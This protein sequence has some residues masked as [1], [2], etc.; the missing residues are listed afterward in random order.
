MPAL[1]VYLLS[2]V[3]IGSVSSTACNT[4]IIIPAQ[5]G[6]GF[7]ANYVGCVYTSPV[8]LISTSLGPDKITFTDVTFKQGGLYLSTSTTY[9]TIYFNSS[10]GFVTT[11]AVTNVSYI[12]Y[13]SL[14]MLNG[15]THSTLVVQMVGMTIVIPPSFSLYSSTIGT[16]ITQDCKLILSDSSAVTAASSSALTSLTSNGTRSSVFALTGSALSLLS[17]VVLDSYIDFNVSMIP[18]GG[19][20]FLYFSGGTTLQGVL[21]SLNNVTTNIVGSSGNGTA[22]LLSEGSTSL[23][24]FS[25]VVVNTIIDVTATNYIHGTITHTVPQTIFGFGGTIELW[26]DVENIDL[27]LSAVT[28][29]LPSASHFILGGGPT[30]AKNISLTMTQGSSFPLTR[31]SAT[32]AFSTEISVFVLFRFTNLALI[33]SN[34]S[35]IVAVNAS[36]IYVTGLAGYLTETCCFNVSRGSSAY[37]NGTTAIVLDDGSFVSALLPAAVTISTFIVAVNDSSTLAVST[38]S[39]FVLPAQLL[40]ARSPIFGLY[41]NISN[42]SLAMVQGTATSQQNSAWITLSSSP[43]VLNSFFIVTGGALAGVSVDIIPS[44]SGSSSVVGSYF[45]SALTLAPIWTLCNIT[46]NTGGVLT[47]QALNTSSIALRKPLQNITVAAV[48]SLGSSWLRS[49]ISVNGSAEL[50]AWNW[51]VGS[52]AVVHLDNSIVY[53][54]FQTV[55]SYQVIPYSYLN[56]TNVTLDD[57]TWTLLNQTITVYYSPNSTMIAEANYGAA[58]VVA[59]LNGSILNWT[60][61]SY[62]DALI[63]ARSPILAFSLYFSCGSIIGDLNLSAVFSAFTCNTESFNTSILVVRSLMLAEARGWSNMTMA[64]KPA[65]LPPAI[66]MSWSSTRAFNLFVGAWVMYLSPLWTVTAN[67]TIMAKAYCVGNLTSNATCNATNWYFPLFANGTLNANPLWW[68]PSVFSQRLVANALVLTGN[69]AFNATLFAAVPRSYGLGSNIYIETSSFRNWALNVT[70]GS[71]ST[72]VVVNGTTACGFQQLD[73]EVAVAEVP[74]S[75]SNATGGVNGTNFVFALGAN[76]SL[77]EFRF[78]QTQI[79]SFVVESDESVADAVNRTN[80]TD[81]VF[82][83]NTLNILLTGRSLLY[84][85]VISFTGVRFLSVVEFGAGGAGNILYREN[86][87]SQSAVSGNQLQWGNLTL[88]AS[89]LSTSL[90]SSVNFGFIGAGLYSSTLALTSM[91]MNCSAPS[92]INVALDTQNVYLSAAFI[93]SCT[94]IADGGFYGSVN[95]RIG[96]LGPPALARGVSL[97]AIFTGLKMTASFANVLIENTTYQNVL[98]SFSDTIQATVNGVY[99]PAAPQSSTSAATSNAGMCVLSNV[100]LRNVLLNN[101]Q[102]QVS[103]RSA[104][105]MTNTFSPSSPSGGLLAGDD[106]MCSSYNVGLVNVTL[107]G[108]TAKV[109]CSLGA[110]SVAH[111]GS[112]TVKTVE[113]AVV[114]SNFF[115]S[116]L[117][118]ETGVSV[119]LS[120]TGTFATSTTSFAFVAGSTLPYLAANFFLGDQTS[121]ALRASFVVLGIASGSCACDSC[122]TY[123]MKVANTTVTGGVLSFSGSGGSTLKVQSFATAS[124]GL[125]FESVSFSSSAAMKVSTLSS[126]TVL[127]FSSLYA[128]GSRAVQFVG[129]TIADS[130]VSFSNVV[131]SSPGESIAFLNTT[132]VTNVTLFVSQSTLNS[133]FSNFVLR[134]YASILRNI[135]IVVDHCVLNVFGDAGVVTADASSTVRRKRG[136]I[137]LDL[138]DDLNVTSTTANSTSS[139]STSNSTISNS[140]NSTV[141]PA[142]MQQVQAVQLLIDGSRMSFTAV[143][144]FTPAIFLASNILVYCSNATNLIIDLL[145]TYSGDAT[146]SLFAQVNSSSIVGNI[147]VKAA[148]GDL[149]GVDVVGNTTGI[150]M[151]SI[152]KVS[153]DW[154]VSNVALMA[155]NGSLVVPTIALTPGN[156]KIT[157][158]NAVLCSAF[159]FQSSN[160]ISNGTIDLTSST[161]LASATQTSAA[162]GLNVTSVIGNITY[163]SV[164]W[165]GPADIE[166]N[167]AKHLSN[168]VAAA[169]L[170]QILGTNVLLS[171]SSDWTTNSGV[172][173]VSCDTSP[174]VVTGIEV[175]ASTVV[176]TLI[177]SELTSW[178]ILST[179]PASRGGLASMM[180]VQASGLSSWTYLN[181]VVRANTQIISSFGAARWFIA[182]ATQPQDRSRWSNIVLTAARLGTLLLKSSA[183]QMWNITNEAKN[184]FSPTDGA[185]IATFHGSQMITNVLLDLN[186]GRVESV[187]DA[188]QSAIVAFSNISGTVVGVNVSIP[189]GS[190]VVCTTSA[191]YILPV[192]TLGIELPPSAFLL[193]ATVNE[194]YNVTMTMQSCQAVNRGSAAITM[195]QFHQLGRVELVK[196]LLSAVTFAGMIFSVLTVNIAAASFLANSSTSTAQNISLTTTDV[197]FPQLL[198]SL[199]N[200]TRSTVEGFT[201]LAVGSTFVRIASATDPVQSPQSS[202]SV[203][204]LLAPSVW[205][206]NV[207]N[208]TSVKLSASGSSGFTF[209]N[210]TVDRNTFGYFSSFV[211]PGSF[212]ATWKVI[213]GAGAANTTATVVA[214][215][216]CNA[217][218]GKWMQW[219]LV[220]TYFGAPRSVIVVGNL[221]SA[222]AVTSLSTVIRFTQSGSSG[223]VT[224]P[225]DRFRTSSWTRTFST[226]ASR[227][228]SIGTRSM[229]KS[230]SQSYKRFRIHYTDTYSLSTAVSRDA[231]ASGNTESSSATGTF[232]FVPKSCP[233]ISLQTTPSP[234]SEAH[235]SDSNVRKFVVISVDGDDIFIGY[236]TQ[237]IGFTLNRDPGV[238]PELRGFSNRLGSL[239]AAE[240]WTALAPDPSR[241]ISRNFSTFMIEIPTVPTFSIQTDEV[242][243][244]SIDPRAVFEGCDDTLG[245]AALF[246]QFTIYSTMNQEIPYI[247]SIAGVSIAAMTMATGLVA[248][249]AP[250]DAQSLTMLGL[251]PCSVPLQRRFPVYFQYL[252]SPFLNLSWT[253]V[254]LGGIGLVM[255]IAILQMLAVVL[256]SAFFSSLGKSQRPIS[257]ATTMLAFPSWTYIGVLVLH[258]GIVFSTFKVFFTPD[259]LIACVGVLYM[260]LVFVGL[261]RFIKKMPAKVEFR[262][263]P[264]LQQ[265]D[266]APADS[267]SASIKKRPA[268]SRFQRMLLPVGRWYPEK[269]RRR[270]RSVVSTFTQRGRGFRI[271]ELVFFTLVPLLCAYQVQ[272]SNCWLLYASL[273]LLFVIYAVVFCVLRPWSVKILNIVEGISLVT[274]ALVLIVSALNERNPSFE[275]SLAQG[276]LVLVQIFMMLFRGIV[277][278]YFAL[279][280][281]LGLNLGIS[282]EDEDLAYRHVRKD[283]ELV[284]Q[285]SPEALNNQPS[286]TRSAETRM[287]RGV[288]VLE[289]T[290]MH[291]EGSSRVSR[292]TFSD[293]DDDVD[294]TDYRRSSSAMQQAEFVEPEPEYKYFGEEMT[295][296]ELRALMLFAPTT[297][298]GAVP[299]SSAEAGTAGA[300]ILIEN[301]SEQQQQRSRL[302]M[303]HGAG[304]DGDLPFLRQRHQSNSSPQPAGVGRSSTSLTTSSTPRQDDWSDDDEL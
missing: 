160:S 39:A 198:G 62:T 164:T 35:S 15:N 227:T 99:A 7:V 26:G 105:S 207:V 249:A 181:T 115:A 159:A 236:P 228:G 257:E 106:A 24:Y 102:F 271:I 225:I 219:F 218:T 262:L 87:T 139:N 278:F 93:T 279:R 203:L 276:S 149:A 61:W 254:M 260:T 224:C 244:L 103:G 216:G 121:L 51:H 86:A 5:P 304:E 48:W 109:T 255:G 66:A 101:S 36:I 31:P 123:I 70:N 55:T 161:I 21:F 25:V 205:S 63:V 233:F 23:V 277:Y 89:A 119:S 137:V 251:M 208:G 275:Y 111:L 29:G 289:P 209:V 131:M 72:N 14:V 303:I 280:E 190:R 243:L 116:G 30:I 59:V 18:A 189:S 204:S 297:A 97:F 108:S 140:T 150:T 33:L 22:F 71:F 298:A 192:Q 96:D 253:W 41:V 258:Q 291:R 288:T 241:G 248:G 267:S 113:K 28:A 141:R 77:I 234:L 231:T 90:V 110:L 206:T 167:C 215:V 98:I 169:P 246:G 168:I 154:L 95:V 184:Y 222:S 85:P 92:C 127:D 83:A 174:F 295:D 68:L 32:S 17:L 268:L 73:S 147:V 125:L 27:T 50:S 53:R 165:D 158:L 200:F 202:V 107:R 155:D 252:L 264:L 250:F 270:Y 88:L 120:T 287:E 13:S 84:K 226:E 75:L 4:T 54:S 44:A 47:A 212:S 302:T 286:P 199:V 37:S 64:W 58:C 67:S 172:I 211:N 148:M 38:S 191:A 240:K 136:N 185:A 42:K 266:N 49:N 214:L 170:G 69:A 176:D 146:C 104:L 269:F 128:E 259:A 40:T 245:G 91:V 57:G 157:C 196:V 9:L 79:G 153:S 247:A 114:L 261:A 81:C 135:T 183:L 296:A 232:T 19:A 197:V 94:L 56:Q 256:A 300:A 46:L 263:N 144:S 80:V 285:L 301:K 43:S 132:L 173:L 126:L 82:V 52:A 11:L 3:L 239:L 142:R 162:S 282:K 175:S 45:V 220:P 273:A 213:E 20:N 171:S 186:S 76:Q 117:V 166:G 145:V 100:L 78:N 284:E 230:S 283:I 151:T 178:I 182:R 193:F 112:S 6:G 1:L 294:G 265:D 2:A 237:Y 12:K 143:D 217:W 134:Y 179:G 299:S 138:V 74:R 242:I 60:S 292:G 221:S 281:T 124:L 201:W 156:F 272:E 274:F 223:N 229:S 290:P 163:L 122:P 195:V 177:S 130:V 118:L 8:K 65:Y 293:L 235:I 129:C 238:L 133:Y 16:V 152:V 187:S 188:A 194:T 10:S 180:S 34:R 210:I